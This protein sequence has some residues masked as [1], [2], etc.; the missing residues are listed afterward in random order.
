MD[1]QIERASKQAGDFKPFQA[2]W[3]PKF[4]AAQ[5]NR[6]EKIQSQLETSGHLATEQMPERPPRPSWPCPHSHCHKKNYTMENEYYIN[7]M[8]RLGEDGWAHNKEGR[9]IFPQR[10]EEIW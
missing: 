3:E 6:K 4:M 8:G 1:C 7:K 2:T 9:I 10:L 5:D